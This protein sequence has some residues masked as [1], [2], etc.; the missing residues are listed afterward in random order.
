MRACV[1]DTFLLFPPLKA[2]LQ[3]GTRQVAGAEDKGK[4]DWK[5]SFHFIFQITVSL[6]QFKCVYEM[7]TSYVSGCMPSEFATPK[8]CRPACVLAHAKDAGFLLGEIPLRQ[9]ESYLADVV[10]RSSSQ[11]NGDDDDALH[12]ARSELWLR[13]YAMK[14]LLQGTWDASDAAQ[15][16]A[17]LVGMDMHP[18]RNAEQGL[19]C[20]G[21]RK[22]GVA[23]GNRLLG[24]MRVEAP[25]SADAS[26]TPFF[27]VQDYSTKT[28]KLLIATECSILVPGPRSVVVVRWCVFCFF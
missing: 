21:S 8:N 14:R 20:L 24:M 26:K 18:R 23:V 6:A 5:I 7:L 22:P 3:E 19:A 12:A 2:C 11:R 4:E 1:C 25:G 28:H 27:W 13:N 17:A 15:C 9:Y 16:T 10:A